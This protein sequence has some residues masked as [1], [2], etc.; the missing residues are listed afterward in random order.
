MSH[1][2]SALFFKLVQRRVTVKMK[3]KEENAMYYLA[4]KFTFL[5]ILWQVLTILSYFW[6][7]TFVL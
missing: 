2:L 5:D 1:A 7:F 4:V 3:N 6:W